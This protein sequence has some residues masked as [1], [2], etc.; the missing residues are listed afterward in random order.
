MPQNI[1]LP[2]GALKMTAGFGASI[3]V[4]GFTTKVGDF[5]VPVDSGMAIDVPEGGV[6]LVLAAEPK[7]AFDPEPGDL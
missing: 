4:E 1:V 7:Q 5:E 3:I 6:V 2:D